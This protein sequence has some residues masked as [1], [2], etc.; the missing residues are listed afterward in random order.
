MEARFS[1]RSSCRNSGVRTLA[2]L[3]CGKGSLWWHSQRFP[4]A[5]PGSGPKPNPSNL[6]SP[7]G[8]ASFTCRKAKLWLLIF[9]VLRWHPVPGRTCFWGWLAQASQETIWPAERPVCLVLGEP[10]PCLHLCQPHWAWSQA[11]RQKGSQGLGV[12][13]RLLLPASEF[14]AMRAFKPKIWF[15]LCC[16]RGTTLVCSS[17]FRSPCLWHEKYSGAAGEGEGPGATDVP[18]S[19]VECWT[20]YSWGPKNMVQ[21]STSSGTSR[22]LYT[23]LFS[24]GIPQILNFWLSI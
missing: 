21:V 3:W 18:S 10:A 24:A 11:E 22:W 16:K 9:S 14:L 5:S 7:A 20:V 13:Q 2:H 12:G 8:L 23:P 1:I 4:A 15:C 17:V 19:R 6:Q